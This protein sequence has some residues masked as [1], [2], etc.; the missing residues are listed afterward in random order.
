M[1]E[2]NVLIQFLIKVTD[3]MPVAPGYISIPGR[4]TYLHTS[5]SVV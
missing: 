5:L 2:K 3:T 1:E 4:D